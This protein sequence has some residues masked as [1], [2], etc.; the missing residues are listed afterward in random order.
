MRA[1][2]GILEERLWKYEE[3]LRGLNSYVK[4][5]N[6]RAAEH[7][8]DRS[9]IE[10]DLR[11]AEHNIRFYEG[12][13]ALI[14]QE[15]GEG[16]GGGRGPRGGDTILPRTAKQGVV[17]L[18]LALLGLVAGAILGSSLSSRGGGRGRPRDDDRR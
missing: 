11:E 5:L 12:E 15:L 4:E 2:R 6:D 17:P 13:I 8:T 14:K 10:D 9:L 1:G 16:G 3:Q 18:A 7:G